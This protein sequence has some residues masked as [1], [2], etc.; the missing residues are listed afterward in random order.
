M[1][2][3]DGGEKHQSFGWDKR[4]VS[5]R[6]SR[7]YDTLMAMR[8]SISP[9]PVASAGRALF[10]WCGALVLVAAAFGVTFE[11]FVRTKLGQWIDEAALLGG[12]AFL[13]ADKP[14]ASALAFLDHMPA[15][16]ALLAGGF[17]LIAL[18]RRRDFL[19][20]GVAL[21]MMLGATGSTQLLKHVLLE[22]PDLNI[23]AASVNS[24]PS[25]HTTFAAA[26][27]AAIFIV[28]PLAH[29]SW[30]AL[31]GWIYAAIAGASTLVLG[32]HRPS[33][34]IAAYLVV[35]WWCMVAGLFLHRLHGKP[36]APQDAERIIPSAAGRLLMF[37][38]VAGAIVVVL[39]LGAALSMPHPVIGSL[40]SVQLLFFLVVGLALILGSAMLVGMLV[41]GIF[42]RY[43]A[44]IRFR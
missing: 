40:G 14:R 23:S 36:E 19:R 6:W 27:M 20:P 24:F 17:V 9:P 8:S 39:F 13:A 28:S 15:V 32:W 4:H 42:N 44:P 16:S 26:S 10:L 37:A 7:K 5:C 38:G 31:L 35:A 43:G 25:G 11:F 18:I 21:M 41:H 12:Q 34:V 22:R 3:E 30:V 1:A 29:R 33:D 2:A